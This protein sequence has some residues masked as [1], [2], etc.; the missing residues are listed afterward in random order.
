MQRQSDIEIR[1]Q[2]LL[3][4]LVVRNLTA[5][6]VADIQCTQARRADVVEDQVESIS[7]RISDNVGIAVRA[8]N[9]G[10]WSHEMLQES[11]DLFLVELAEIDRISEQHGHDARAGDRAVGAFAHNI[12]RQRILHDGQ[13]T[14]VIGFSR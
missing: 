13:H 1:G 9:F 2:L 11:T 8:D 7:P 3:L 6:E 12:G 5:D 14:G 10:D 4:P